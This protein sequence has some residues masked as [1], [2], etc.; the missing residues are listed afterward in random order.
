MPELSDQRTPFTL[1]LRRL[2]V[3][4]D[5]SNTLTF[6]IEYL[7]ALKRRLSISRCFYGVSKMIVILENISADSCKYALRDYFYLLIMLDIILLCFVTR[8]YMRR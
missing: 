6:F 4:A 7:E 1:D 2:P 3:T 8:K 5:V